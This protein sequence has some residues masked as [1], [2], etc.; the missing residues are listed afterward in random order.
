MV[1]ELVDILIGQILTIHLL[2]T[3]GKQLA[4]KADKARLGQF[5]YQS[6]YILVLHVGVGIILRPCGRIRCLHVVGEELQT[7]QCFPGF[8][9]LLPVEH[10][11]LGYLKVALCH[12]CLLYLVLYIF[13]LYIIIYIQPTDNL[14]H[15]TEVD[16]LV[17]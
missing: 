12:E 17:N 3:V 2:N 16:N 11:G 4:V 7:L 13:Y 8:G 15:V 10:K 6:G 9:M 1:G 5:A 14:G